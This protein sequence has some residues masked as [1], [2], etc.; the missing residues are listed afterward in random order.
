MSLHLK[1]W[2]GVLGGGRSWCKG[3]GVGLILV[4][5]EQ[6]LLPLKC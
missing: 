5:E 2:A 1:V 3:P 4:L 6:G